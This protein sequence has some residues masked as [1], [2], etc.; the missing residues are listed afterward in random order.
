[1]TLVDIDRQSV[2][3]AV[4]EY[5]ALG[6]IIFLAKYGFAPAKSYYLLLEGNRYPSK[7]IAGAAHGYLGRGSLALRADQFS[8][9]DKTV[10]QKL[11][12]LGFDVQGPERNPDWIRDEL[13]LALDLYMQNPRSPPG[14][15]SSEIQALSQEL[16][17]LNLLLCRT[18]GDNFRNPNGVYMKVMNF[19]RFDAAFTTVGKSG[20]SHGGIEDERV[21]N[22]YAGDRDRLATV[23]GAIRAALAQSVIGAVLDADELEEAEEG[24]LL[25]A[26]HRRRER[27]R[28]L[29]AARKAKA[30]R[31]T[32]E[33]RCEAC[34]LSFAER[35][36]EHGEGYIEIHHTRPLHTLVSGA[37]TALADLAL[38]CANCH[39]MIHKRKQWLTLS[40]LAAILR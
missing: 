6:E 32:G 17:R 1:M 37:K 5:D 36:G 11:R 20:L 4:A 2:L 8:G 12:E 38:V 15:T 13:I 18:G 9:G 19:R 39:R 21:W 7:A 31:D 23:A 16:N 10:G 26:L 22:E 14:K 35:Y 29:V 34:N 33:L 40:E 30:L 28:K 24:Q 25:T 3:K 27:S